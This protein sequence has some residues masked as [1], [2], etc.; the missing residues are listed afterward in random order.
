M[1]GYIRYGPTGTSVG[2]APLPYFL[3]KIYFP[4]RQKGFEKR[5]LPFYYF[6]KFGVKWEKD[7]LYGGL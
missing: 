6:W 3:F 7:P 5:R 4:R 1:Y 2:E